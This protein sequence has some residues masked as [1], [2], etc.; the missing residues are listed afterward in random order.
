MRHFFNQT[1]G[2]R[3]KGLNF[4]FST[5]EPNKE[6]LLHDLYFF[7][8]KLKPKEYLYGG[9]SITDKIQQEERCSL[10]TKLPNRHFNL[11]YET[12]LNLQRYISVVKKE[13]TELLKKPNY[14]EPNLTSD[15][16]LKLRYLS[17]NR[18]LTI[19]GA[20]KGGKIVIIGAADYIKHWELLLNYRGFFEKLDANP[21]LI[22]TEEVK[23]K[24][25]D[26]LKN[27]YTTKQGYKYLTKNLENPRIPLFY[28]LPKLHKIFDLF[29]PLQP[30]ASGF[31]SCTCNLSKFFDS[32]LKF[33]AQKCKSYIR[34]TKDF[35]IKLSSIK[36]IP[37][38]RFLVTMYVS[39]LYTNI[40]H[41][42]SAEGCFEKLEERKVNPFHLSSSKI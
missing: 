12:P 34:Y 15:E 10:K 33:Q 14:Q 31:D 2:I 32:F 39:S 24:I 3:N 20:Q 4:A 29:P 13:V 6:Q 37:E 19:R 38:N 41:E 22:Y 27:N 42:E 8:R 9:D 7:C 25:D 18:N 21:T 40:D 23:Q 30:T 35:L 28:G 16:R 17:E 36:N 26:T 5:K 1:N 11:T